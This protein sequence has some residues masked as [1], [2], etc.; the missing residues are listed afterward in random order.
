M[1]AHLVPSSPTQTF[2][3]AMSQQKTKSD[4]IAIKYCDHGHTIWNKIGTLISNKFA[5]QIIKV[6]SSPRAIGFHLDKKCRK[7][8]FSE[9]DV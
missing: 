9:I 4:I 7:L 3:N 2:S 5:L 8:I 1:I 6:S